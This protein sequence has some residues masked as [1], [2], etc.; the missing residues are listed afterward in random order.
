MRTN[1]NSQPEQ[2][3]FIRNNKKGFIPIL[4][5]VLFVV[6]LLVCYT[7]ILQRNFSK[8]TVETAVER[9]TLRTDTIYESMIGLLEDDDF[10][11][12][13]VQDDME[14]EVYVRLQSELNQMRK[15]KTVRYLYTAKRNAE[16]RLVYLVDGLDLGAEDFAYPGTAIEDEILPNLEAALSGK[17]S[18]S[19]DIV[20][21]TW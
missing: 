10:T 20:D 17:I 4:L 16:G 15:L 12:I 1:R 8:N 13:N 6:L 11:E 9:N 18:Y 14:T 7:W 3:Q 21:T 19:Q 5:A 2:Q